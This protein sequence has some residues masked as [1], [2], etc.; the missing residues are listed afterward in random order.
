MVHLMFLLP[1]KETNVEMVMVVGFGFGDFL[2]S[3]ERVGSNVM[4]TA[5]P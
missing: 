4:M 1:Q 3:L 2:W 5:M